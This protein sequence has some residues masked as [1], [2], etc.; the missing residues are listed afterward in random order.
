M[1][2]KLYANVQGVAKVQRK[3][4]SAAS[5][6]HA[7]RM[8]TIKE[9][10]EKLPDLWYERISRNTY[11]VRALAKSSM[12]GREGSTPLFH[13]GRYVASWRSKVTHRQRPT[14]STEGRVE[15]T[16]KP[17]GIHDSRTGLTNEELASILE[18]GTRRSVARPHIEPFRRE[19][20]KLLIDRLAER[21]ADVFRSA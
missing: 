16:F 5:R 3:L 20:Q 11:G 19:V 21:M 4:K 15:L 17:Q 2:M 7:A 1:S 8:D 9:F 10:R 12:Y 18:H 6:I 13:T 14:K